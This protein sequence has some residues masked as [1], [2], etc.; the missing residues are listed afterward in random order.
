MTSEE[1]AEADFRHEWLVEDA[2][3]LG[4]L[5]VIGGPP[6]TLKSSVAIDLAVSIGS[7][8][9][10]LGRFPVPE[11]R[12]VALFCGEI[13]AAAAR[14]TALR[15]CRGRGV[16]LADCAV[17]WE[18]EVPRL[19]LE[20]VRARLGKDLVNFGIEVAIVDPLH[21][22]LARA[23]GP[24]ST[25]L[26]AMGALLQAATAAC[27]EAGVTPIFVH[28]ANKG[29]SRNSTGG[30]GLDLV[31]LAQGGVAEA[32][33]QWLLLSRR[34]P[35]R[36]GKGQHRLRLNVGGSAG[37]SG[38]Y[39]LDVDEGQLDRDFRGRRWDVRVSEVSDAPDADAEKPASRA[40]R[41]GLPSLEALVI[42]D[43]GRRRMVAR[44]GPQDSAESRSVGRASLADM[45]ALGDREA[46]LPG[47]SEL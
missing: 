43:L 42:N 27:L 39:D 37:Q 16:I 4:Q 40:R 31:D 1:F 46:V 26:Y 33:R 24:S 2:L 45:H 35:Y 8:T 9:D 7:G 36:P 22:A 41:R 3:V 32:S 11:P 13:G 29:A 17:L 18:F 23:A 14:G 44:P 28:Q 30:V 47:L 19:D 6:K 20:H 12:A 10:F 34:E 15:V 25:N 21:A 38:R 5:G